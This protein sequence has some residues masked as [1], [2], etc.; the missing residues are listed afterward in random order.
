MKMT[1][2]QKNF[3]KEM[4]ELKKE[5]K[6]KDE[7]GNPI[8]PNSN[9]KYIIVIIISS[10]II[11]IIVN[12]TQKTEKQNPIIY[13]D[14]VETSN[15][16]TYENEKAKNDIYYINIEVTNNKIVKEFYGTNFNGEIN[17]SLLPNQKIINDVV[18]EYK[19]DVTATTENEFIKNSQLFLNIICYDKD[20]YKIDDIPIT[21]T[22]KIGEET[23]I[24]RQI[25]VP[26]ETKKI[27]IE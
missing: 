6:I 27:K 16:S 14:T 24:K 4:E 18:L 20:E 7:Y 3:H 13:K 12:Y 10:I 26:L 11:G 17:F 22:L 8:K 9:I 5:G 15:I 21:E 1:E 2:T 23:K 19:L 25:T